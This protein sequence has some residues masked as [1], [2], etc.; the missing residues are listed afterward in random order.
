MTSPTL[1][2]INPNRSERV[3]AAIDRAMR[4]IATAAG[5]QLESLTCAEGPPGIVTQTDFDC[6]ANLVIERARQQAAGTQAVVIGCFSDPGLEASRR[7]VPGPVLGLGESGLRAALAAG[8]RVGVVAVADAA[9]E[10][11]L[12]YWQR[13]G[14]AERVAGE[15]A[16]NLPIEQSGDPALALDRMRQAAA[17]LRDE[18]GADV[19][20]LG[21]AGMAAL[22]QPLENAVALPVIDP[23]EAAAHAAIQALADARACKGCQP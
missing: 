6:A 22:R 19:I 11:H 1:L 5:V 7:L 23:C 10:R 12:R 13:L 4:P 21:C 9:I 8:R 17:R 16:L 3:T 20:L 2:A 18:D 14:L 15:R